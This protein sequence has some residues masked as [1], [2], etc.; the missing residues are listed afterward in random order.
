MHKIERLSR[1]R[2]SRRNR[3]AAAAGQYSLFAAGRSESAA[4]RRHFA[5]QAQLCERLLHHLHQPELVE[6]LGR[7]HEEF[8]AKALDDAS[9]PSPG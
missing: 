3:D 8:E 1:D 7:L 4:D 2:R 6:L 5:R 9:K